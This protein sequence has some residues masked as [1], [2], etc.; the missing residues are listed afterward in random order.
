MWSGANCLPWRHWKSGAEWII[1]GSG[2]HCVLEPNVLLRDMDSMYCTWWTLAGDYTHKY[3]PENYCSESS[4][5][6]C[7]QM[8]CTSGVLSGEAPLYLPY[9]TLFFRIHRTSQWAFECFSKT[10]EILQW[11]VHSEKKANV[12]VQERMMNK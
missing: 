6:Q 5:R 3:F 1:A 9:A 12:V 2:M 11:D 8:K 4:L 7:L 10:C